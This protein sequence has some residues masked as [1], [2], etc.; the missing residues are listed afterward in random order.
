MRTKS[1]SSMWS[2]V[3]G[4][5]Y[6]WQQK[7]TI[8]EIPGARLAAWIGKQRTDDGAYCRIDA[9]ELELLVRCKWAG[10][11]YLTEGSA[12]EEANKQMAHLKRGKAVGEWVC[13]PA[14]GMDTFL[15][16]ICNP[17]LININRDY[18]PMCDVAVRQRG[19]RGSG[20]VR[21]QEHLATLQS[22]TH[23][24]VGNE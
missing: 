1:G 14:F 11:G 2:S 12:D 21:E 17:R 24:R 8:K 10:K 3:R 22:Q 23:S 19:H 6:L 7:L 15:H 18:E 20:R 13:T 16:R 4:N 5:E 9:N